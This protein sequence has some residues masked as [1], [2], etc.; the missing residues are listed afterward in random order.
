M[1]SMPIK[2]S[3]DKTR[4]PTPAPKIQKVSEKRNRQK[5]PR[6]SQH[7]RTLFLRAPRLHPSRNPRPSHKQK[8]S[9]QH[10]PRNQT[11]ESRLRSDQQ[12]LRPNHAANNSNPNERR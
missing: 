4:I 9:H 12:N 1:S 10:Q 3:K 5:E 6:H 8:S 2:A 7:Q 11:Q